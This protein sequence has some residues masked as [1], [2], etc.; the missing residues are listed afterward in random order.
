[1]TH[2]F[3]TIFLISTLILTGCSKEETPPPTPKTGVELVAI[4]PILFGGVL[5]GDFRDAAVRIYNHGPDEIS[6]T[7]FPTK[8]SAPFKVQSISTPCNSGKLKANESCVV[9][10]RFEPAAGG[11]FQQEFLV[12]NASLITTG[13]GL[14]GGSISLSDTYWD[15]GQSVAGTELRKNITVSNLGDFTVP[16]PDVQL[17]GGITIGVNTCGDF[18]AARRTCRIE[19]I[20]K[21]IISGQLSED[22]YFDAGDGGNPFVTVVTDTLPGEPSGAILFENAPATIVADGTQEH[23]ITTEEIRDQFGNIVLDN[24]SIRLSSTNVTLLT[25]TPQPT[26]GGKITF[27]VRSSTTKGFS[28]VSLLSGE[29]NGFLRMRATSGPASGAI[30]VQDYPSTIVAN[31]QTQVVFQL[32]PLRDQFGNIVED[33]TQVYYSLVGQ[34]SVNHPFSFTVLGTTSVVLKSSTQ[35]GTTILQIRS[36]PIFDNTNTLI[37]WSAEGDFPITFGPGLASGVIPI[38]ATESGIYAVEDQIY[39][40]QGVPIRTAVTLGPVRDAYGNIVTTGT[41]LNLTVNGGTNITFSGANP[42]TVN[43]DSSG[44][45]YFLL[46]GN[47]NRGPIDISVTGGANASGSFMVWAYKDERLAADN[48][49]DNKVQFYEKYFS[50][51]TLPA[52]NIPWSKSIDFT[53]T[54]IAD[55]TLF[56]AKHINRNGAITYQT[57]LDYLLM[58]CWFGGKNTKIYIGP[59]L[60]G[61]ADG[62]GMS[63]SYLIADQDVLSPVVPAHRLQG[64]PVDR[65]Y[66]SAHANGY[67]H[68]GIG[69]NTQLDRYLIFGGHWYEAITVLGGTTYLGHTT[70]LATFYNSLTREGAAATSSNQTGNEDAEDIGEYPPSMSTIAFTSKNE[71]MYGF[72]G[73]SAEAGSAYNQVYVYNGATNKWATLFPE[74]DPNER[75]TSGEPTA[76]NQNGI[77]YIP[78]TNSLYI[79]GGIKQYYCNEFVTKNRCNSFPGCSWNDRSSGVLSVAQLPLADTVVGEFCETVN[80]CEE[81]GFSGINSQSPTYLGQASTE[82]NKRVGCFWDNGSTSCKK[83]Q[84][85]PGSDGAGD[86]WTDADDLWQ[87][88]LSPLDPGGTGEVAWKKICGSEEPFLLSSPTTPNP[89]AVSCGFPKGAN[90]FPSVYADLRDRTEPR[91]MNMVWNEIRQKLYFFWQGRQDSKELNFTTNNIT[92]TSDGAQSL[93]YAESGVP[94]QQFYNQKLGRMFSYYRGGVN[95]KNSY[96]KMWDNEPNEKTYYRVSFKLGQG[97]KSFTQGLTPRVRGG[98]GTSDAIAPNT[99]ISVYIYNFT[100]DSWLLVG[101]NT[102]DAGGAQ[103]VTTNGIQEI[104]HL[105]QGNNARDLVSN[106]GFVELLILPRGNPGGSG[107]N[108]VRLDSVVLEGRF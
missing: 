44:L 107:S 91:R 52:L 101:E 30:T 58:P 93:V 38:S 10:V 24:T 45:V 66:T 96:V 39:E 27:T 37:G 2:I 99:G 3:G 81:L 88:D 90:G 51:G 63:A 97:S 108:E 49:P 71:F 8:L 28:T 13:R 64:I 54:S 86:G 1:M 22:I 29:A 47:G 16:S 34:G 100:T 50:A 106:Q 9:A 105:Y 95:Q 53:S 32:N 70:K 42:V 17:L 6:T 62:P 103:S 61:E 21:K 48:T 40:Q 46:S 82:C 84:N 19:L 4:G 87:L 104:A 5:V 20:A 43:T 67:F 26:V 73:F 72:G 77:A 35:V 31:G 12:G 60:K 41:A 15:V 65:P 83:R 57:S 75:S 14:M 36:G 76:R 89:A 102:L 11:D 92:N 33:N 55:G 59:C 98:G 69:Y 23:T 79:G 94:Y 18:L 78:A 56:G 7:D 25:S 74:N 68:P 85:Y 80:L